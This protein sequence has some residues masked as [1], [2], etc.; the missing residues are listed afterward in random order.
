MGLQSA[1]AA[2]FLSLIKWQVATREDASTEDRDPALF[3]ERVISGDGLET[4]E[5]S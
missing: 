2:L 5:Q 1:F 4:N 3:S